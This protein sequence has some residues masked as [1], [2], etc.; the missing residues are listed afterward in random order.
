[1]LGGTLSPS[2]IVISLT[3]VICGSLLNDCRSKYAHTA[4]CKFLGRDDMA[5]GSSRVT[6]IK[7]QWW[8]DGEAR[9]YDNTDSQ[10]DCSSKYDVLKK[11]TMEDI[12]GL[13]C[14]PK[15]LLSSG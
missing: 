8:K 7:L 5:L 12:K 4:A 15:M 11:K 10:L 2:P 9:R 13:S 1:M 6:I 14:F 3:K